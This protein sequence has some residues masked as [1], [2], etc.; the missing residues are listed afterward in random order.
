MKV[1]KIVLGLAA[2]YVLFSAAWQISACEL[3]NYELKDDMQDIASQVGLR[4]GLS[5][6]ASDDDLRETIVR[7]AEKYDIALLPTQVTVLRD[8]YGKNA[9]LYFAANYSVTIYLPGYSF[10]MHFTPS[11]GIKPKGPPLASSQQ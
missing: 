3:A 10:E 8:G 6:V 9:H 5:D 2:F 1:V 4:I 7:K 11:G